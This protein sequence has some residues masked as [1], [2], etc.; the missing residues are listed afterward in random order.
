[1]GTLGRKERTTRGA[2][3]TLLLAVS[4]AFGSTVFAQMAKDIQIHP[5]CVFCGM[6]RGEYAHSRFV[7]TYN[8]GSSNCVCSIHCAAVDLALNIQLVPETFRV[9][10]YNTKLLVDAELA[11]WVIGGSKPGVM[12]R[13]AKWA[14]EKR[15]DAQKFVAENGGELATFDQAMKATY[16]DMYADTKMINE[17]RKMRDKRSPQ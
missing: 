8:D 5:T 14:F 9:A 7:V 15:E 4:V 11:I 3:I 12:T 1:M 2:W 16:E 13:R 6:D 17:K 10:D